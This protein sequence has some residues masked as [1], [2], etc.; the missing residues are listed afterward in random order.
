MFGLNYSQQK[1]VGLTFVLEQLQPCSPFGE[2]HK[3]QITAFARSERK[4]L[5]ECFE[6]IEKVISIMSGNESDL[7]ELCFHLAALKQIRGVI[8]KCENHMLSQVELFE[9][10][11]FLL[12]FEKAE[13]IFRK[14]NAIARFSGICLNPLGQALNVLDPEGARVAAFVPDS[15]QLGAIRREKLRVEALLQKEKPLSEESVLTAERFVL[16]G[17]EAEEETRVMRELSENLRPHLSA[18]AANTDNIGKLD[19]IVAK[20]KLALKYNGVRPNVC[21]RAEVSL[22]NMHNPF[23]ADALAKSGRTLTKVTMALP[24]GVTVITGANMGGKT[25]SVKTAVLNVLLCQMGFFVFAEAAEIPLFDGICLISED[26]QDVGRGL[27]AFGAEITRFNEIAGRLKNEFLFVAMD[28]FARG[29]NPRE[30]ALIFRAIASY[31]SE[32]GSVCVMTTHY[33][34]VVTPQFKHYQV[35]G[36]NFPKTAFEPG[37]RFS[38]ISEYMDYNLIETGS[39][40]APPK[41]ALNICKLIGLEQ[42]ILNRIGDEYASSNEF[43]KI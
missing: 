34:R 13:F 31:L 24:K 29:T 23:A 3:K 25:V 26:M 21:E 9:M 11:Q 8:N 7:D 1:S 27:S 41:D 42:E 6:N 4:A 10:K 12:T 40:T 5:L 14:I 37:Y 16:V 38:S 28:E 17:R 35:A 30:G 15:P 18:I 36:L 39:D 2:E 22:T 19:L 43:L 32:S 33:N 20:A